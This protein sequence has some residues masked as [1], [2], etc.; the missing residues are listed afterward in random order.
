MKDII[1][2]TVDERGVQHMRKSYTGARRGEVIIKLNVEVNPKAFTPPVLEQT[3]YVDDWQKGIDMED[4]KFEKNIITAEEADIVRQRRLE[5]M[6]EILE[7]Q[8]YKIESPEE[9]PTE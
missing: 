9:E 7:S 1:F 3:V 5:K 6:R 2:L 8:G 4:V